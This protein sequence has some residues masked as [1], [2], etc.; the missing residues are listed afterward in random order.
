MKAKTW[1]NLIAALGL[2]V[3]TYGIM[4]LQQPIAQAVTIIHVKTGGSTS[5]GC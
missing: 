3:V 5:A 1:I 2:M 4:P